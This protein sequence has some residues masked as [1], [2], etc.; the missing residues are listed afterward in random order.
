MF[1][2]YI[3]IHH[4]SN[5]FESSVQP[6]EVH[7]A[8]HDVERAS[9]FRSWDKLNGVCDHR[10]EHIFIISSIVLIST[11]CVSMSS[12]SEHAEQM[13]HSVHVIQLDYYILSL[14][15]RVDRFFSVT[16]D[17]V[18]ADHSYQPINPSSNLVQVVLDPVIDQGRRRRRQGRRYFLLWIHRVHRVRD[19]D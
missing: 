7:L 10:C 12:S 2:L 8:R 3:S 18:T 6:Q 13:S 14:L 17:V 19:S 16:T 5:I 9:L 15:S 1:H 11:S 4:R